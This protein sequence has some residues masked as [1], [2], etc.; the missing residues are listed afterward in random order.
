MRISRDDKGPGVPPA[1]TSD[2]DGIVFTLRVAGH[3]Q[4]PPDAQLVLRC[5]ASGHVF[6]R[7]ATAE[8]PAAKPEAGPRRP[9]NGSSRV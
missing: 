3:R 4:I 1:V 6:A 2:Q 7:L 5:D 8:A 9:P